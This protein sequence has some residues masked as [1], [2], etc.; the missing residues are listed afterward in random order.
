MASTVKT[1]RS[2]T[3]RDALVTKSGVGLGERVTT[4]FRSCAGVKWSSWRRALRRVSRREQP[5][6][7]GYEFSDLSP[8]GVVGE[9]HRDA[10]TAS[11]RREAGIRDR[12]QRVAIIPMDAEHDPRDY[13]P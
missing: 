10:I 2:A 9:Q 13:G 11:A 8:L 1:S 7:L 4:R 6:A 12:H 3:W 5:V